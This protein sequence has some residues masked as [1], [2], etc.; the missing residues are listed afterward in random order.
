MPEKF[1]RDVSGRNDPIREIIG[2]SDFQFQVSTCRRRE[3]KRTFL[4]EATSVDGFQTEATSIVIAVLVE[5]ETSIRIR[6]SGTSSGFP[7]ELL[8]SLD[9]ET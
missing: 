1:C 3:N 9:K 2:I 6:K 7:L 8:N 5:L 4:A